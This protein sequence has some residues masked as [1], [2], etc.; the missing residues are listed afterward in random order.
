MVFAHAVSSACVPP[1]GQIISSLP[2]VFQSK[3][4]FPRVLCPG[5]LDSVPLSLAGCNSS[6]R[7]WAVFLLAALSV[8]LSIPPNRE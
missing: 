5:L 2:S 6:T 4:C 8:A 3:L 1:V 7:A